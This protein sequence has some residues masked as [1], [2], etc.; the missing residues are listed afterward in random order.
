MELDFPLSPDGVRI[1]R[2]LVLGPSGCGKTTLAVA[3]VRELG[4]P[5]ERIVAVGPI[6]VHASRL[7]VP[8]HNL[9]TTDRDAQ[10]TFFRNLLN[11][12][13][14]PYSEGGHDV[15]L[16]L[17]EADLYFSQAGRTYGSPALQEIV[18]TGRN[19]GISQVLIA[20][21]TSDLAKNAISNSNV[22]FMARTNEPN[23]LDYA[24]RFMGDTRPERQRM[25]YVIANLP[26][27]VF[28]VY[29]PTATPKFQGFAKVVNGVI[30]CKP[31]RE[32]EEPPEPESM[33]I[34]E[35]GAATS[36]EGIVSTPDATRSSPTDTGAG[37]AATIT[38]NG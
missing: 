1:G 13:K 6:P 33:P 19:N 36:P 17:D 10:E 25:R 5:K 12:A 24:E 26:T 7:G 32:P 18:N 34:E 35:S 2:A 27:H 9:S 23:L 14:K 31:V 20:R 38:P 15:Q 16:V 30:E 3:F 8:W 4:T 11:A 22:V 37:T 29:A 28:L 21:G